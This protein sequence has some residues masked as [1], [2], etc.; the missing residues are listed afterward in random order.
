M[1]STTPSSAATSLSAPTCAVRG[2]SSGGY[3][4][5][6]HVLLVPSGAASSATG[7]LGALDADDDHCRRVCSAVPGCAAITR[8]APSSPRCLL[9]STC[10]AGGELSR[11]ADASALVT[12]RE[13]ATTMLALAAD[14][15]K[16]PVWRRL[17]YRLP[18]EGS[19]LG[20]ISAADIS[21]CRR[22]C[23][24][25]PGCNS[26]ARQRSGS[27]VLC[28]LKGRCA[29]PGSRASPG[30]QPAP[31]RTRQAAAR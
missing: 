26:F 14:C 20:T 24:M 10:L 17:S 7:D 11:A 12:C 29:E 21:E 3:F 5:Y 18:I 8:E 30:L 16:S 13:G 15:T 1:A 6:R 25:M 22:V 31:L 9:H 19:M 28:H 4:V 23:D 27:G 2:G